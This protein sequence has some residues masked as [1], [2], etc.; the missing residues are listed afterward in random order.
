MIAVVELPPTFDHPD[1]SERHTVYL[2]ERRYI[3]AGKLSTSWIASKKALRSH[4]EGIT[5]GAR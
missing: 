1:K 3:P 4:Y 5:R 2:L